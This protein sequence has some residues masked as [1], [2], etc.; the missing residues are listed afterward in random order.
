ML[1]NLFFYLAFFSI[2]NLTTIFRISRS[3]LKPGPVRQVNPGSDRPGPGTDPGGGKNP[4]G[5]W[6]GETR[7]TRDPV[8]P[9]KPGWDR[10][11]F[12]WL[13]WKMG[14][15]RERWCFRLSEARETEHWKKWK[16]LSKGVM[17]CWLISQSIRESL[18]TFELQTTVLTYKQVKR[19]E[20]ERETYK[21][22]RRG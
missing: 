16:S 7:S 11:I 3:V 9:V 13:G 1:I 14:V 4:L 2:I 6:S 19:T 22:L 20:W 15:S 10:S 21:D 17:M 8:H 12:F 5:N 18:T